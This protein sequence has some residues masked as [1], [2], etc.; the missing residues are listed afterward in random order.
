MSDKNIVLITGANT[1]LGYEAVRALCASDRA[2]EILLGGRDI[3]KA[4]AAAESAK[5]EFP[6]SMSVLHAVQ[7]DIEDDDSIN[8]LFDHVKK[9]YGRLDTLVNNA[10]MFSFSCLVRKLLTNDPGAS[11]DQ[12]YTSGKMTMRQAWTASW[13]VNVVGTQVMTHTFVP[14]L[15]ASS[16]PRLIFLASGTAC[17]TTTDNQ[18]IPLNKVPEAGWPKSDGVVFTN[19]PAYR[20]SKTG[21]NMMMREWHRLLRK[22]GVKVWG[23]SPGFLATGLGGNA[24]ANKNNGAGDPALGGQFIKDVVEGKRDADVGKVILRDDK[25]QPW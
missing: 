9:T 3:G 1:G 12:Q 23:I 21:M 25:V 18:A 16:D 24:E 20:S 22:D 7:I 15:L 11:F 8:A 17:L 5:S 14:L 2:H 19:I 13:T 4:K 6:Q 10:G